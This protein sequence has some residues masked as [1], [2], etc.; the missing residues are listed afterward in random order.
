MCRFRFQRQPPAIAA[1][2]IL[3]T[4]ICAIPV[5]HPA[6]YGIG[7]CPGAY[8]QCL[9]AW[10]VDRVAYLKSEDGYLNLAGLFWLRD[11]RNTFGSGTGNDLVFPV[12][13]LPEMGTFELGE[14]GVEMHVR[15][16]ADVRMDG[17]PVN[18]VMMLDDTSG[19]ASVVTFGSF[20][21][22]VIRRDDRFAVRLRDFDRGSTAA[23][24]RPAKDRQGRYRY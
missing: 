6:T 3:L 16:G 15:S 19:N 1:N 23:T 17:Q 4:A 24:L 22:I 10:K 12:A 9:E 20:A 18:R 2:L 21:W 14:N 8:R 13:A 5:A 11:G 7:A